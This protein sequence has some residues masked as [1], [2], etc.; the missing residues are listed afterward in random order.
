MSV[1][2]ASINSGSNGNCYYVGTHTDAVLIDAGISCRETEIRMGRLG[3]KMDTIKAI[4]ISHEHIDHI[5]GVSLLS[6]RYQIPVYITPATLQR[7]RTQ[8]PAYLVRHFTPLQ[9]VAIGGLSVTGFTKHHDAIDPHS[10]VVDV[11]GI[12][13]GVFTDI[14]EPCQQ[15]QQHFAQC[16]AAFL[17]A[18]YDE[19]M[20]ENGRYPHHLR[21]RIRGSKGHLSNV[22][23]LELFTAH[24]PPHMTH[25]LLSHLSK[26]NN[27]P[28]LAL[29]VFRPHAGTTAVSVASRYTESPLHYITGAAQVH[30]AT[31]IRPVQATLF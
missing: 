13:I 9:P 7:S 30:H 29:D 26:D 24:R 18:N 6:A 4:F 15:V 23:A 3:L 28:D 12:R 8:P 17:E 22:Q 5:L 2:I 14:G 25:L 27:N 10:F 31:H 20:L 1:F 19:V 21:Q 16:H 11:G